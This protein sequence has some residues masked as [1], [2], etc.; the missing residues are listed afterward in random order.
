[1]IKKVA[2]CTQQKYFRQNNG[3]PLNWTQVYLL[4]QIG[5]QLLAVFLRLTVFYRS[6]QGFDLSNNYIKIILYALKS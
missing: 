6:Y 3:L 1:M 4:P 5:F 2:C